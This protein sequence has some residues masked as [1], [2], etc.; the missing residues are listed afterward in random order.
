MLLLRGKGASSTVVR[1]FAFIDLC[2]FTDAMDRAGTDAA[3]ALLRRLRDAVREASAV[4]GIRVDKWLGDGAMLVSVESPPLL[5]AVV[6]LVAASVGPDSLPLRAGI[7]SGEA[8]IFEGEDYIGKPV[9]LAARLS[10]VAEAG[11]ILVAS[12]GLATPPEGAL[13]MRS[14]AG[15]RDPVPVTS[16]RPLLV[17]P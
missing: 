8:V 1:T 6:T 9:N 4:H 12:S 3:V 7:A 16:I 17:G 10:D 5:E 15:F 14:I 13:T 11:E 2:G